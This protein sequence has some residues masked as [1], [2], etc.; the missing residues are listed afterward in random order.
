MG[1][2]NS[3]MEFEKPTFYNVGPRHASRVSLRYGMFRQSGIF[4]DTK[5]ITE[6]E[7]EREDDHAGETTMGLGFNRFGA[8]D[9]DALVDEESLPDTDGMLS[10]LFEQC[11]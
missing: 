2:S 3:V 11:C 6:N 5:S 10:C 4:S 8:F 7:Y 9:L 1:S